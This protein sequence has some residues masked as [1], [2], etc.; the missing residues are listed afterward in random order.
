MDPEWTQH[1]TQ[2]ALDPASM[3]PNHGRRGQFLCCFLSIAFDGPQGMDQDRSPRGWTQFIRGRRPPS[4]KW[5]LADHRHQ[6]SL[7]CNSS[8]V[9]KSRP[10]VKAV[11]TPSK[12]QSKLDRLQSVLQ[13]LGL[14][15]SSLGSALVEAIRIAKAEAVADAAARV[16]RLEAA[17]QLLDEECAPLES[18]S[19]CA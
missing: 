1:W 4:A 12:G 5:P 16:G 2:P 6:D 7:K 3:G 8:A 14:E 19:I 9:P 15:E 13:V 18:V 10:Q 17:L 11:H